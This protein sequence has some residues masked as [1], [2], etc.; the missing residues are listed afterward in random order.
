[1]HMQI[2]LLNLHKIMKIK[3]QNHRTTQVKK[4]V[5]RSHWDFYKKIWTIWFFVFFVAIILM[6]GKKET[7]ADVLFVRDDQIEQIH[8]AATSNSQRDY[9]FQDDTQISPATTKQNT[10]IPSSNNSIQTQSNLPA[11]RQGL[12]DNSNQDLNNLVDQ[13]EVQQAL[14]QNV[15]AD[16]NTQKTYS[17]TFGSDLSNYI[18][19][20]LDKQQWY[21]PKNC[22]TPRG[23]VVNHKDFVLA[24][25]QRADVETICNVQRRICDDGI[26]WWNYIQ[27]SC[28]EDITYDYTQVEV[29]SYNEPV[30][31]PL[32]QPS[33][34]SNA[35][36]NFS[37]EWKINQ[38]TKTLDSR[39]DENGLV[40]VNR[41]EIPQKENVKYNCLTPR[42][43]VVIHWQFVKAY[44]SSAGFS[45]LPCDV[46]LRLCVN[47]DLRW[48]Y[49]NQSCK[50]KNMTSN[51]YLAGNR[52]N[53]KPTPQDITDSIQSDVNLFD[54]ANSSVG[55]WIRDKILRLLK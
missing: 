36:A 42:W 39:T 11:G 43:K 22:K 31:D 51:D 44:K 45:D 24:Y 55:N 38:T 54:N 17:W 12:P 40:I 9:L 26:L 47:G 35:W 49:V 27:Q 30:V 23:E 28:R 5:K 32:V 29:I 41:P 20:Q 48:T 37:N 34:A 4:N 50:V 6:L 19:Q 53:N 52:D 8:G 21:V 13:N 46:Q 18:N 14:N 25:E 33:E 1:M 15:N 10:N 2:S 16:Q 7:K 3:K